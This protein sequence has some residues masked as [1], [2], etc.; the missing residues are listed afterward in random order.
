MTTPPSPRRRFIKRRPGWLAIV[1]GTVALMLVGASRARG[2][3]TP[4][5]RIVA[6]TRRLACPECDGQ[7]VYDSQAPASIN[8]RREVTELV[9]AGRLS[10]EEI[11][12]QLEQTY[13][14]R[15]L[16]LPS[17]DGINVLL[18]VLPVAAGVAGATALFLGFRTW[19]AQRDDTEPPSDDDRALVAAAL[20]DR[21]IHTPSKP[22]TALQPANPPP[23]PRP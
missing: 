16:L 9:T 20:A 7:P 22:S 1:F 15:L 21:P 10:N 2:N 13:G 12:S 6:I 19:R 23:R 5:E 3:D 17:A 18:W 14:Q 4:A 8:I 11:I